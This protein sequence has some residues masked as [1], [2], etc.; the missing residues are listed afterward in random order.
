MSKEPKRLGRGLA[1]LVAPMTEQRP[2]EPSPIISPPVAGPSQQHRLA[3]LRLDQIRP[4]PMQP[5]RRFDDA[6][7]QAL[8]ESLKSK[9]TLQ[10]VVVRPA[11]GGYELIAGERRLRAAS[12]AGLETI[13]A[14]IRAVRDDDLLELA[15][16]ENVHRADLN[17]IERAK[18]YKTLQERYGLSHDEI[19]KK[20]GEDRATVSNYIRILELCDNVVEMVASGELGIGHA[21]ALLGTKD[22]NIQLKLAQQ[23]V[24]EGWSVRQTESTAAAG[25]ADPKKTPTESHQARPPVRDM[26]EQ[27]TK[28]LGRRVVI[29]EGRKRHTGRLVLEY[30]SLEDFDRLIAM[31]G[32]SQESA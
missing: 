25:K 4:N 9:G 6:K 12:I 16:I 11:E 30:Y 13:P 7:I 20:M 15:L 18:A 19:G 29:K 8:A 23:A 28:K 32:V 3:S 21:K 2:P 10:P 24:R 1:S 26:E 17:P 31:L 27:L 14:I 5:R 22:L